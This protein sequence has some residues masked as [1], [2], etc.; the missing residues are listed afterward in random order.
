M[1]A[2]SSRTTGT[3]AGR[4]LQQRIHAGADV[5]QAA[6]GLLVE[7]WGGAQTTA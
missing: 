3:P 6:G 2:S 4:R 7:R 1:P 5:E